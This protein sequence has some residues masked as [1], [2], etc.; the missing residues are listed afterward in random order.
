MLPILQLIPDTARQPPGPDY[1]RV[2]R[3]GCCCC[4]PAGIGQGHPRAG[5]PCDGLL[6]HLTLRPPVCRPRDRVAAD[7]SLP[8]RG[9]QLPTQL[10]DGC[11]SSR[12]G[13]PGVGGP[14]LAHASSAGLPAP[15]CECRLRSLCFTSL[16]PSGIDRPVQADGWKLTPWCP[17]RRGTHSRSCQL[18]G[19]AGPGRECRL[20]KFAH[21]VSPLCAPVA[22]TGLVLARADPDAHASTGPPSPVSDSGLSRRTA[23]HDSDVSRRSWRI[24][25]G[26]RGPF[27]SAH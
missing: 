27:L 14:T 11:G 17:R 5:Y 20:P 7:P 2:C 12:P 4:S 19:S 8:T 3:L 6:C 23:S 16:R 9:C 24:I 15:G 1:A 10:S 21:C 25:S 26:G 13:A 18:R 22:L